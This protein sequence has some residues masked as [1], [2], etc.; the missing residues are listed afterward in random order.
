MGKNYEDIGL[1]SRLQSFDSLAVRR[2]QFKPIRDFESQVETAQI[3]RGKLGTITAD[4]ITGGTMSFNYLSGGTA[5]LGGT[6]DGDG[7]L[8]VNNSG[9]TELFKVDSSGVF[10]TDVAENKQFELNASEELVT[11]KNLHLGGTNTSYGGQLIIS[12]SG[13]EYARI[14][15]NQGLKMGDSKPIE[16]LGTDAPS[17]GTTNSC[18]MYVD[19]G[20]VGGKKRLMALFGSGAAQVLGTEP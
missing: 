9:G 16:L 8:V 18:K 11:M 1:N 7:V 12:D 5:S 10:M 6:L 3:T 4:L 19:A 13:I 15:V 2:K 14:D 17:A 20:G